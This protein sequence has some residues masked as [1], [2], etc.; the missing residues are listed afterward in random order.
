MTYSDLPRIGH[1]TAQSAIVCFAMRFYD[2]KIRFYDGKKYLH[3]VSHIP[4]VRVRRPAL[5]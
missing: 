1:H 5:P 3:H 4:P 2:D